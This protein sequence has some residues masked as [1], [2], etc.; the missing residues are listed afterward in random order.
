M[1]TAPSPAQDI[2]SDANN[3]H[4]DHDFDS[5]ATRRHAAGATPRGVNT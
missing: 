4:D 5:P 3:K 2:D 1:P